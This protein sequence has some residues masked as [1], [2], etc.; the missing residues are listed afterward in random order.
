MLLSKSLTCV[1]RVY[2]CQI[3]GIAAPTL[4][5]RQGNKRLYLTEGSNLTVTDY[6]PETQN[7][8]LR[9]NSQSQNKYNF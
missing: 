5:L 7:N 8:F 3:M 6:A 2:D 4:H 1:R 9:L